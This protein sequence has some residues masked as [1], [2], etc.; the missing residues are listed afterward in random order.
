MPGAGAKATRSETRIPLAPPPEGTNGL[1]RSLTLPGRA[2]QV[3]RARAFIAAVLAARGLC[4]DVACL[5]GSELVTNAVRHSDSRLPGGVVTV[6]VSA[7]PGEILVLVTDDGGATHPTVRQGQDLCAEDGRGL[8]LVA[9][10]SVR[11]GYHRGD[12]ELTTWFQ[13]PAE[14]G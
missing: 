1:P 5:L 11:W 6:T 14:P 10:L 2:A 12:G 4:E 7:A 3:P 9:Q 8:L 13:I